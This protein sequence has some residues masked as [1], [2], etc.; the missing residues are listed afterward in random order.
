MSETPISRRAAALLLG[1]KADL[2]RAVT[3]R[4]YDERPELIARHGERGR[5]KC[6]Q[7]MHHNVEQLAPAV[8]LEDGEMF[9]RYVRWLD[10]MLRSRGVATGDVVRCLELLR[11]ETAARFDGDEARL[12][13]GILD[14]G[15]AVVA[16]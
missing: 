7:D 5:E 10:D 6:L 8:D 16:A 14:V 2:A 15:L 11:D 1:Q 13:A 9:A 4:L 12:I 3:A